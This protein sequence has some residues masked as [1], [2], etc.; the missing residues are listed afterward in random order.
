[1]I[2]YMQSTWLRD[3]YTTMREKTMKKLLGVSI[4]AMLAVSPMMANAALGTAG[5]SAIAYSDGNTTKPTITA[6]TN[7]ATTTYVQGAYDA[8]AE[9]HNA[10]DTR[11]G[12]LES[13]DGTEGSILHAVKT[14]AKDADFSGTGTQNLTSATTLDGAIK[15]LDTDMGAVS[16]LTST[17]V[18]NNHTGSLVSAVNKIAAA[19]DTANSNNTSANTVAENGYY[20]EAGNQVANNLGDL[21]TA[22][23]TNYVA[24]DAILDSTIP[25]YGTWNSGNSTGSVAI[26]SLQATPQEPAAPDTR[27]PGE[28]A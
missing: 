27:T 20:I 4:A 8:L 25:L 13:S 9:K 1:M 11:V 7:V 10:L 15:T 24:I 2:K 18:L 26:R 14:K 23:R 6:G 5:N 19:V 28:G 17:T 22:V 21:D 12:V 16:G 3:G